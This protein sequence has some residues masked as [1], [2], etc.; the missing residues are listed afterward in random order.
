MVERHWKSRYSNSN[1]C[2]LI[3]CKPSFT[4]DSF[5]RNVDTMRCR[6]KAWKRVGRQ[7]DKASFGLDWQRK[8]SGETLQTKKYGGRKGGVLRGLRGRGE[9]LDEEG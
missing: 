6:K 2:N 4:V 5:T 7:G 1:E 8:R 3:G 9:T